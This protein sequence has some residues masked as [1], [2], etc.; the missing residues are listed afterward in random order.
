MIATIA[1]VAA[2]YD[3]R[4]TPREDPSVWA[5]RGSGQYARVN[6][7]TAEIDTVRRVEDPSGV[8]QSG[9]SGAVL[10][11]GN[12][13]IWDIDP[14]MPRDL[15]EDGG[16]TDQGTDQDAE[17]NE[18]GEA[19]AETGGGNASATADPA[20]AA[21]EG[22][23]AARA[24]DGTRDTVAAGDAVV[25]RTEDGDVFLARFA[26][27]AGAAGGLGDP[28]LLDPLADSDAGDADA[29][30]NEGEGARFAS[31]A[32]ALDAEGR[33]VL[34]SA[35]AGELRWYD[36]ERG[37]FMG[38]DEAP[39]GVPGEGVQLAIVAGDWVLFDAESGRLWREGSDQ[40]VEF[41]AGAD[42]RLQSSSTRS[43]GGESLVAD[44][45]GLWSVTERGAERI[46][47]GDGTPVQPIQ[48]GE[49]RYAAWVGQS[50]ARLWSS[51]DGAMPLELDGSVEMPGQPD[52]VFRSNG[53]SAL[54]SEQGTGMMWTLPEGRLIPVEQWSLVDPPKERSG[55]V[56]V[57]DVA[58]QEP[59]VAVNDA[60]GVRAGEPAPLPVLLN[61]YD[62]N[63]KDVLTIV[64]DGL[65]E[66]LAPEFGAVSLLSDGQSLVIQPAPD[67]RGTASFSYRITDGVHVS[68]PAT[69]SLT[70]VA[71]DVNSAPQWC[72]V[73]GCQREWP[74][75]ELAPGGTLV[76]PILEG[77][78]DPEGDPMML[79][80][81]RPVNAEDPVR[82]L[83][84][85]DGRFALRHADPNA[86]DSDVPVRVQV[87]DSHGET[88]ERDMIVQIR[89]NARAEMHPIASTAIVDQ[90][91]ITRPLN[92]IVGG[93]GSYALVDA[94]LQ[95][96]SAEVGVNLG[97]GTVEVRAKQA[98]TSLVA[99]TARDTGTDAEITGVLRVTALDSR[100][101]LGL[102]PLRAFVRP[103]ADTTID[104]LDAV[105][106]ANSRALVVRSAS[107][108]DGELRADV[109]EH[110]QVRVSGSTPDG[111]PGRI[112]SADVVIEEG[113]EASTAR[114]TV[115]QIAE[116]G[117]GGA[118]AVADNITV[119]AGAVADI[120]VLDNDVAPPGQRLVLHPEIGGS[121]AK[122]ELAFASGNTLRYLAPDQPGS[123][124]LTYTAYGASTPEASDVGQVRVTVLPREGNRD[125]QPA[126][127]TVRLAPGERSTVRVPLSGVDPDGDRVRLVGVSASE[128]PQLTASI[129]SRSAA[130]QVEA[131][132]NAAPGVQ[133]LAYTVRDGF[134][135]EAEGR[136]RVILVE[137]T[138][139]S[140]AP[141]VFSDYVRM[142][143]G[144][145]APAVVQ[146]L[147]NDTDPAGGRL[148][149]VEVVPNVPGGED[150]PQ[151]RRLQERLDLSQLKRGRVVVRGAEELGTVSY[152]YTVRSSASSST[153]DGLIVVQVSARVGQQAPTVRDTVLS[154]RDRAELERGGVDVVTDRVHWA[155]GDPGSLKLS[156]WG[157][158]ADRF[159]A[160]GSRISGAYRAE[161]DLVPFRLT[162]EDLSGAQVQTFGFLV[163]PPLDEL[164]LTLKPGLAPLSV[165]EGKTTEARLADLVDLAGGDR[166][167]F[168]TGAFPVQRGQA[169]CEAT[170]AT[171]LRY[172]AGKEGPW[173]D[174]CLISV[175]L[176]EQK[177]WTQLSVPVQIVPDEPVAEL[178]PLTRTVAPGAS[179]TIDLVDMVRWQGGRQ[180]ETA[181]LEFQVSG[182]GGGFEV[183]QSGSQLEVRARAD[184]VPG[185]ED[186]LVVSVAS[187]GGSQAPLALRVGEAAKDTPRGATV[188][189]NCTVG[190]DCRA[191]LIGAPGEY[192]PFQGKTGGGLRLESVEASGCAVA[193]LQMS[194]DG[195]SA[196]W[197]QGAGGP[198]GKCTATY[199][200]RDA[201]NRLGQGRIELDAQGVPRAPLGVEP[202]SAG[203]SSVSVSVRLNGEASH[204]AV[205]GV[206]LVNSGGGTVGSCSL[207]GNQA[208][209]TVSGLEPG[210]RRTYFARA[211]N[212]V[213][214]SERS[215]NG[216]ET[217]A[218]VPPAPPTI[219]AETATWPEN[220]LADVGRV[221]VT[222]GE[223]RAAA[224]VLT[225]D[226][227]ETPISGDGLYDLAAGDTHTFRVISADSPDMIPP[228]YTGSDGGRGSAN[229]ANARPIGAPRP[230]ATAGLAATGI[231]DTGWQF[232]TSGF[233]RNGGDELS[234]SY[235]LV[236]GQSAPDCTGSSQSGGG[237][238]AFRYYTGAVCASNSYGI[239]P[240]VPTNSIF[241]GGTVPPPNAVQYTISSFPSP[242]T[243]DSS[244]N[245]GAIA[246]NEANMVTVEGGTILWEVPVSAV[247][248]S[249]PNARA[250]QCVDGGSRC[251]NGST[252]IGPPSGRTPFTVSW[253]GGSCIDPASDPSG[254]GSQ[255]TITGSPGETPSYSLQGTTDV[256]VSW[257]GSYQPVVF[258][259]KVCDP[260]PDPGG[261][262]G[263]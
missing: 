15:V 3:A 222:I 66:G 206:E 17:G 244:A 253:T 133:T 13:R 191:Q 249:S 74:S 53:T 71:P 247:T 117:E 248:P 182:G 97:A 120:P 239:T 12:G 82:V 227:V 5:M 217:W 75:P 153:A 137:E 49:S 109:L 46:D 180:G 140:R 190:S 196:T 178:E 199:T 212:A 38:V 19:G 193:A 261:T 121:G 202:V 55:T 150:S 258:T 179:Q 246:P 34:F 164:R 126:S 236:R 40:P 60:F 129:V 224:R 138:G 69:V 51:A 64:P 62:P 125:P 230:P 128:D 130:L 255:F 22:P 108:V 93:S 25:F 163:I 145:A 57:A 134:G 216:A 104:V 142:V 175:K 65:G 81:A 210:E 238:D 235:G 177:A 213:G 211:V 166:A 204:P 26:G 263:P 131:S 48:L 240:P 192:D 205:T 203:A 165:N 250:R 29:E 73:E 231:A 197:P 208:T 111:A 44:G 20:G 11:H 158:A 173:G 228:G 47:A 181:R 186:V 27:G 56:V 16:S 88:T 200:V 233:R 259:G 21:G 123:Y 187:G 195:V 168:K 225:I 30:E 252:V 14:T 118:I 77:W 98:G 135:G 99:I 148:E 242:A 90:P 257:S 157:G 80:S 112:G 100:P 161:G 198:G 207:A 78:V 28:V 154:A 23:V 237:L 103:L 91:A 37:R 87:A 234:F 169:S 94:S 50:G 188:A 171:T 151:Y 201:Q 85:G 52:P 110:A 155:A 43:A 7:L 183:A 92:R 79:A 184:A 260:P 194:G 41:D 221:R 149:L 174:S 115:F 105:P 127:L 76:L 147:D 185:R 61:D 84:T 214:P 106:G 143:K 4:E 189:L 72:P 226:G 102:P 58:E 2:G 146:P 124:T 68:E 229:S 24:P 256:M 136:L 220:T 159:T 70:V 254:W 31:S 18:G 39:A 141:V 251:S 35:E 95:S 8:L 156:V 6:T 63:R 243:T 241:T 167:E 96:G 89:S 1:V 67:A 32:V 9:S 176:A 218:Y 101:Q 160:S 232:D 119:R 209:C 262:G 152:R 172:S 116:S 45:S 107:V 33:L 83:V 245:Y 36:V 113:A 59:P 215:A 219:S 139:G 42:A 114:L 54:L 144:A 162:G 10:S 132:R 170:S 223:S 122:G 86:G